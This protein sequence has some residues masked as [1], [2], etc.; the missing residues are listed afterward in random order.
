MTDAGDP[1]PAADRPRRRWLLPTA[2][3]ASLAANVFMGS[4]LVGQFAHQR[5]QSDFGVFQSFRRFTETMPSETR[6]IVR[7]SFL[8]RRPDMRRNRAVLREA[9]TAVRTALAAEP[10]DRAAVERAFERLRQANEALSHSAQ[11]AIIEAAGKL[12]PDQRRRIAE[13]RE[14][15]R[16]RQ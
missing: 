13:V 6:D 11:E 9:R 16:Q 3:V 5:T 4:V 12:P 2:L 8:A 15:P 1:L 14:R 7:E 10:Y